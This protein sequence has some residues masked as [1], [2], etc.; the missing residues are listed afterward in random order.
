VIARGVEVLARAQAARSAHGL[1]AWG[2]RTTNEQDRKDEQAHE[3]SRSTERARAAPGDRRDLGA[4]R[5][6]ATQALHPCLAEL[7]IL[8]GPPRVA[9]KVSRVQGDRVR[10]TPDASAG[11]D[12]HGHRCPQPTSHRRTQLLARYRD[13]SDRADEEL[14]TPARDPVD[15]ASEHWGAVTS[16]G[17]E[18]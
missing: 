14:A 5:H 18:R 3:R 8:R 11:C 6:A 4:I 10:G 16:A 7:Q 13:A 1:G 2:G 9:A 12:D 15:A 17:A